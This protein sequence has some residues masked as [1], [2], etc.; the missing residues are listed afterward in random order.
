[1]KKVP[2]VD[3]PSDPVEWCKKAAS[4]MEESDYRGAVFCYQESL[5]LRFVVP[6]VWFNIGC[7]YDQL[8][9][10][11]AALQCFMTSGKMFPEDYRFPAE[12][13]RL[14][15]EQQRFSEAIAA[16][17]KAL[18][19]NPHS[20]I[21]LS[22]KA[23]Y[24]I[25]AGDNQKALELSE[26]ALTIAPGY[27]TALLHKAHAL[28]NLGK[29]EEAKTL[30][31][32]GDLDDSRVLKMLSNIC[33]RFGDVAGGLSY[34]EKLT[35]LEPKDDQAWSLLGTACAYKGDKIKA[36][37]AFTTAIKLNPKEKSY[38]ENLQAVKKQH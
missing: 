17:S 29:M 12:E 31:A 21:L 28:V 15:A 16:I 32:T 38:K 24:L 25:F 37:T 27:T 2:K 30:L 8:N 6:D 34:A 14:L 20:Q 3:N 5:K 9:D 11:N 23:G 13:A 10:K 1:M 22:N 7:L 4:L 36:L 26:E 35:V 19:I 18:E 33:L